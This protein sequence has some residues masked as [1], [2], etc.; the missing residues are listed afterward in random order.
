[1]TTAGVSI[2]IYNE[3]SLT[4]SILMHGLIQINGFISEFV[5]T[6]LQ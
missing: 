3:L 6:V 1:M 4:S 2:Y 5:L